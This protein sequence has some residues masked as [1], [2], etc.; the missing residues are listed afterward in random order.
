M[1]KLISVYGS[2]GGGKSTVA[3]ALAHTL[4]KNKR[5]VIL[6][7]ADTQSPALP[8]WVPNQ[9]FTANNSLGRVLTASSVNKSVLKDKL[10]PHPQNKHLAFMGLTDGENP[11]SYDAFEREKIIALFTLLYELEF[12]FI[13]ADCTSNAALDTLT[14]TSMEMADHILRIITPDI[15][16]IEFERAQKSWLQNGDFG[17]ENSVRVLNMVRPITPTSEVINSSGSF[18]YTLPFSEGVLSKFSCGEVMNG[19]TDSEGV[20]FLREIALLAQEISEV[21]IDGIG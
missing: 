4:T 7:S 6:I 8:V 14:I 19:F 17:W 12:D 1:S 20:L 16:G 15:K 13:I 9:K 10:I 5:N 18:K 11:L 21:S 3:L 2:S